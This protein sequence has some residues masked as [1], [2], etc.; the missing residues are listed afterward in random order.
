MHWNE[1]RIAERRHQIAYS[2]SLCASRWF[3][4]GGLPDDTIIT[5]R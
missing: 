2:R 5:R 1:L 3:A 4:S